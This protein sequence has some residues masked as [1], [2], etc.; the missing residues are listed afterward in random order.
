MIRK[1]ED[2]EHANEIQVNDRVYRIKNGTL[3]VHEREQKTT[4]TY[5]RTVIPNEVDIKGMILRELYCVPYSGHPGF[6][7]TLEIVKQF[8]YWKHMN[9]DV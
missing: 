6:T 8:F 3:K 1:L 7:R 5:W 9:P 2:P 4:A